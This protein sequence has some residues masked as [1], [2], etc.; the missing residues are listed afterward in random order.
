VQWLLHERYRRQI[1]FLPSFS[2][3]RAGSSLLRGGVQRPHGEPSTVD[4]PRT[5]SGAG[6]HPPSSSP[7][8]PS[9]SPEERG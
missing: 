8:S 3:S 2:R 6:K 1:V 9:P 7:S 5:G 4:A